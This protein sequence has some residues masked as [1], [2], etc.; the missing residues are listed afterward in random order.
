MSKI[1]LLSVFLLG[2]RLTGF[3]T[4][5]KA[6][7]EKPAAARIAATIKT[8]SSK[9]TIRKFDQEQL[10]AYASDRDF[11][12]DD[13]APESYSVWD[14][15]WSWFWRLIS[16]ALKNRYGGT[17]IK[18]VTIAAATALVVFIVL[19]LIGVNL[20][21]FTRKAKAVNIPYKETEENIHEIDFNKEI[22]E[23]IGKGN[24]RLGVRLL[25]LRSLKKLSDKNLIIW[26]PEK[27][28]QTYLNEISDMHKK[29]QF[30]IL[31]KQ[32]EYV[33]YGEFFIDAANFKQLRD[34]YDQ[35][36]RELI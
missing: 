27:T 33:W 30:G 22:E 23:A 16:S 11:I 15:F 2:F 36:S 25:Y 29:Q 8:D 20:R 7:T 34:S 1:L 24:F 5:R 3:C 28:N 14:R 12:Y 32:F 9:V 26:Q 21:I 10:K 13:A 19:K 4:V 6:E 31:T 17:I 18:Y 35:F